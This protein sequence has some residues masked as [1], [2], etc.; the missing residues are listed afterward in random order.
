MT[1]LIIKVVKRNKNSILYQKVPMKNLLIR[2]SYFSI[3]G[4]Y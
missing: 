2:L 3:D 1:E 4:I